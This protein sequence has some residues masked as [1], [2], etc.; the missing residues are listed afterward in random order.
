MRD[1]WFYQDTRN[2]VSTILTKNNRSVIDWVES[3]II[4]FQWIKNTMMIFEWVISSI[5]ILEW[6][7]FIF[8]LEKTTHFRWFENFWKRFKSDTIKSFDLYEWTTN[9]FWDSSI[10][11]LWKCEESSQNDSSR[12]RHL[13]MIKS[14][15][16]KKYWWSKLELCE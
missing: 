6:I 8:I 11:I 1:V 14:N 2:N 16:L 7:L 4:L 12:I 15:D 13:K 3:I 10:E 5:F 9:A